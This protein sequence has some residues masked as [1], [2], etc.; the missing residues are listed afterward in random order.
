MLLARNSE[1]QPHQWVIWCRYESQ[2]TRSE[3]TRALK[4][5]RCSAVFTDVASGKSRAG[6][7]ELERAI[8]EL[9]PDD[10]LVLAEWDRC[11]R[12]M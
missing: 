11:T 1:P 6:R 8:A 10:C 2:I 4:A 12:S 9:A 7:P 5:E 3:E